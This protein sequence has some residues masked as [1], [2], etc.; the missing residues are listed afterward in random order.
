MM[1]ALLGGLAKQSSKL[2]AGEFCSM[3]ALLHMPVPGE[4]G[5][6]MLLLE[7]YRRTSSPPVQS[8]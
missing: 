2:E 4:T 5:A 1:E 7:G 8:G 6:G 3:R